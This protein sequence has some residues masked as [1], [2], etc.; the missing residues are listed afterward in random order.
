MPWTKYG[1]LTGMG[2]QAFTAA[3]VGLLRIVLSGLSDANLFGTVGT[4][5]RYGQTGWVAI[6]DDV[7]VGDGIDVAGKYIGPV[8]WIQTE[9]SEVNWTE[10]VT[11]IQ[12]ASGIAYSMNGSNAITVFAFH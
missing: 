9:L 8:F 7:A 10:F 11:A 3:E 12:G 2:F 6:Y 4:P 5:Q 1:P